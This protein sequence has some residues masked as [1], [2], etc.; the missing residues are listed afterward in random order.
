M[1]ILKEI[2][3]N[4]SEMNAQIK[5]AFELLNRIKSRKLTYRYITVNTN[6]KEKI[7]ESTR[8]KRQIIYRGKMIRLTST[9]DSK[10]NYVNERRKSNSQSRTL[11]QTIPQR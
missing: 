8:E 7:Q 2:T 3:G 10:D 11:Y 5:N 1:D 4:F 9:T 6:A